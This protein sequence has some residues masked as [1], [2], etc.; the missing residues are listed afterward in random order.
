MSS[1]AFKEESCN[2]PIHL[3]QQPMVSK[4]RPQVV[5]RSHKTCSLANGKQTLDRCVYIGSHTGRKKATNLSFTFWVS[6]LRTRKP[7]RPSWSWSQASKKSVWRQ[8]HQKLKWTSH[9]VWAGTERL[10]QAKFSDMLTEMEKETQHIWV[11]T[12]STRRT[13]H[14]CHVLYPQEGSPPPCAQMAE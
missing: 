10:V 14:Q 6:M 11:H 9:S 12:P 2:T 3:Y 1:G 4:L 7:L 5:N 13:Q 8:S